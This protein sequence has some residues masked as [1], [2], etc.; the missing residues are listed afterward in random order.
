MVSR[1]RRLKKGSRGYDAHKFVK[2]RKRQI[3]V[4]TFGFLLRMVVHPANVQDR[5]GAGRLDT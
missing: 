4:D 2:G 3:V 1:P 5:A